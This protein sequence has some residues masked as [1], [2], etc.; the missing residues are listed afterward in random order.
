MISFLFGIKMA[1]GPTQPP[2]DWVRGIISHNVKQP[3]YEFEHLPLSSAKVKEYAKLLHASLHVVHNG[4]VI[5]TFFLS[6]V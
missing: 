4:K 3:G 2:L 5:Y 6:N 1:L